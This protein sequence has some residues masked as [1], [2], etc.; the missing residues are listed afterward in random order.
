[1]PRSQPHSHRR[2]RAQAHTLACR[3]AR[4]HFRAPVALNPHPARLRRHLGLLDDPL[5]A[6]IRPDRNHERSWAAP[7][8]AGR[9][10]FVLAAADFAFTANAQYLEDRVQHG[11]GRPLSDVTRLVIALA[12]SLFDPAQP[13]S[14]IVGRRVSFQM[15]TINRA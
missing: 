3:R 15:V 2:G 10:L 1:M 5:V 11:L 9:L 13:G 4:E 7:P 14:P 12:A 6:R 8:A